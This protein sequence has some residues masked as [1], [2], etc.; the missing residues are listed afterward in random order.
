MLQAPRATAYMASLELD[1][2][3]SMSLFHAIDDGD[4]VVS[5]EEFVS[6]ALRL[7][8]HARAQ[9]LI[10]L[11]HEFRKLKETLAKVEVVAMS[12]HTTLR[13]LRTQHQHWTQ[14]AVE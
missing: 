5:A 2:S 3:E 6:G 7:K 8:G 11:L 12:S 1:V 9:D 14:D 10:T 4:G 13:D